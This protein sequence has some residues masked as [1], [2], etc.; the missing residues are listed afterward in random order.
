MLLRVFITEWRANRLKYSTWKGMH[1][2]GCTFLI[3]RKYAI[4]H[5]FVSLQEFLLKFE[6]IFMKFK[7]MNSLPMK[8]A[9]AKKNETKQ[10]FEGIE[11]K[12]RRGKKQNKMAV[13]LS[14]A[15]SSFRKFIR[16]KMCVIIFFWMLIWRQSC[17]FI[18]LICYCYAH[19]YCIVAC[20][21]NCAFN[22][23]RW[24]NEDDRFLQ[25]RIVQLRFTPAR[26]PPRRTSS[27]LLPS[28]PPIVVA[29]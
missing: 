18:S 25:F 15:V 3:R 23:W 19:R 12:E 24:S 10:K 22:G 11:K 6:I 28:L 1:R 16:K 21:F 7:R 26:P 14:D 27:S 29:A 17:S 9:F 4:V 2:N 8:N 13:N 5:I 20:A